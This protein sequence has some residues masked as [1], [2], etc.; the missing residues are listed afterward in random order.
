MKKRLFSIFCALVLC[1]ALL[2]GMA[3][4]ASAASCD[5]THSDGWTE[6]TAAGGDL[7]SGKYYLSGDVTATDVITINGEVTLC[8]NG[9]VL[10][11]NGH[12]INVSGSGNSLT[13]CDCNGSE[14]SHKF[15]VGA[16][17][18]WTLD[19]TNGAEPITGG[20]IT[21]GKGDGSGGC[22]Y[23]ESGTFNMESGSIVGNAASDWL[24]GGGGV[25]VYYGSTFNMSG[26]S[27]VGNAASYWGGGVYVIGSTF[28]MSGGS[29]VGNTADS[30]G[31]VFVFNGVFDMSGGSISKNT[32]SSGVGVFVD[33]RGQLRL[34]SAPVIDGDI[35][36]GRYPIV[37]T[38]PLSNTE[39]F[40]LTNVDSQFT[41]NWNT[42]MQGE[43]PAKYFSIDKTDCH[44]GLSYDGEVIVL[45]DSYTVTLNTN[46]GAINGGNITSYTCGVGTP[47]P[48]DITRSGYTFDGWYA[49]ADFSGEP[50]T[51][52]TAADYGNKEF[53]AKW[54]ANT[55]GVTLHTDGG[56]INDGAFTS[57]TYGVGAVLPTDVERSGYRF[58]GWYAS[59][60]FSGE[61]VTEIT[62]TD[63]GNKAF[64][65]KWTVISSGGGTPAKTPSQQ[66]ADR[67]ER[68]KDG[69]TVEITLK[70]GQTKLDK[71]VFEAL[72]GRDVTLEINLPGG[73]AWTVSGQDIPADANLTDLDM[74]VS[75]NTSTI[76]VDIINAVT[77]EIS[78]VQLSLAHEGA[79]GFTLTLSAPLGREH[80]DL[81]A[82]LYHYDAGALKFQTA[83]RIGAD[84]MASLKF[85][86]AS[87]Y[88]IVI[89]DHSHALP[90]TD[91]AADAWYYDAVDY[92]YQ[93]GLM[94]GTSATTF[95]PDGTMTRAM[96][97]TILHRQAGVPQ[98]N[99]ALPFDDVAEGAWYT[100]AVRWAA[101][102][103]IVTG[104]SATSFAPGDPITREQLA[105]MLYR[106][107][108]TMGC[109][110]SIGEDT[111]ILSYA[112]AFD[113]SEWAVPAM[114]WACGAGIVN[115]VGGGSLDPGGSA[116]R[117]QTAA[118]LMRF[119]EGALGA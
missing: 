65:A 79:F 119:C 11:L 58:D 66:A 31:G 23:V 69:A 33:S 10:N 63:L 6:L 48:T 37:I 47:L 24:S 73:V 95:A 118:M 70:T 64:W 30:G 97:V 25:Y 99:Y 55:Y 38:G 115:G 67:I 28:N 82:N 105:T 45:A 92:V 12:Y 7:S 90:F 89:D 5:G 86:H 29:I 4:P 18:L 22:V 83:A 52:I 36:F 14:Q 49:S 35:R 91:A 74:G 62:S 57:Y 51:E 76:P 43:D 19:K 85:T 96:L 9:H 8:L 34:S 75:M 20:V 107:A 60:D 1:L 80:A 16:G 108:Q 3:M 88:A 116:T 56:T 42:Y 46:E 68:A 59:A 109:D 117:A 15:T 54:T 114:Q 77:G 93:N 103:G 112:D 39:P 111:N 84:G 101:S 104:T 113:V 40:Q 53:W 94:T 17:G 106:Y 27:I 98:V 61:P 26:G 110:V 44:L 72:A 71:E 21:G 2:P 13:L 100:E 32:A 87:A 78:T 81:W 41:T 50:V 102:E